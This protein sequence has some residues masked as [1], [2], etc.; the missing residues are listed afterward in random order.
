MGH[1]EAG[2]CPGAGSCLTYEI[3]ICKKQT[4]QKK[5]IFFKI[6]NTVFKQWL[7]CFFLPRC[8]VEHRVLICLQ[9]KKAPSKSDRTADVAENRATAPKCVPAD[10]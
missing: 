3:N 8:S 6:K 4:T 5:N 7:F 9:I 10:I 2:F 1:F